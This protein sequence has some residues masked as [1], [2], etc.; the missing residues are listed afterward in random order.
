MKF[1]ISNGVMTERTWQVRVKINPQSYGVEESVF[2][3]LGTWEIET[4]NHVYFEVATWF[5]LIVT[6]RLGC[7]SYP[8]WSCVPGNMFGLVA[9]WHH[10]SHKR[11]PL[12]QTLEYKGEHSLQASSDKTLTP[13]PKD[14]CL[15]SYTWGSYRACNRYLMA[16]GWIRLHI[17]RF[18][19]KDHY[20]GKSSVDPSFCN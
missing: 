6:T 1:G 13:D 5:R 20:L 18:R 7:T 14:W 17:R 3:V 16:T 19:P 4:N 10:S 2:L 8:A 15:Y 12:Y 11:G 9:R